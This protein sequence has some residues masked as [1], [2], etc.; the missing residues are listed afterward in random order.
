SIT[1]LLTIDYCAIDVLPVGPETSDICLVLLITKRH[2]GFGRK[3]RS[4]SRAS[5]S[6]A[7]AVAGVANISGTRLK[8]RPHHRDTVRSHRLQE[9]WAHKGKG[10]GRCRCCGQ[11]FGGEST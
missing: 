1:D 7:S 8:C 4:T 9:W 11:L 2:S 6:G 10:W 5:E 3:I